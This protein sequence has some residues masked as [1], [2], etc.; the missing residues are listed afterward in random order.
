MNSF[1]LQPS[2]EIIANAIAEKEIYFQRILRISPQCKLFFPRNANCTAAP[3]CFLLTRALC[4]RHIRET[5]YIALFII[6]FIFVCT[7]F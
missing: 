1:V 4:A 3:R 5:I 7:L 2:V 6:N